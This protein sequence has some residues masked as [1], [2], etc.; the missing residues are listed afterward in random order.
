[1]TLAWIPIVAATF[2]TLV[3]IATYVMLVVNNG[4]EPFL[5]YVFVCQGGFV[6]HSRRYRYISFAGEYDLSAA[7][8]SWGLT[9]SAFFLFASMALKFLHFRTVLRRQHASRRLRTLNNV[10]FGFGLVALLGLTMLAN[11]S[12]RSALDVHNASAGVAFLCFLLYAMQVQ[13]LSR[14]LNMRV[15]WWRRTALIALAWLSFIALIPMFIMY[16]YGKRYGWSGAVCEWLMCLANLAFGATF[17]ADFH[18]VLLDV[19]LVDKRRDNDHMHTV[20]LGP[21]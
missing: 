6:S 9:I 10:A 17:A 14:Q 13:N 21:E 20:L 5:P 19:T 16:P 12:I 8:F 2:P 3:I 15:W 7:V 1:M 4:V 18:R 11:F